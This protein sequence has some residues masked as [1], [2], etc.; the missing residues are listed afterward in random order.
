MANKPNEIRIAIP[1]DVQ[2][3]VYA[4]SMTITHT[5]EEFIMDF[6]LVTPPAGTVNARVI[7]SPGHVKRIISAL[8]ENVRRYEA[9]FGVIS[10]AAEPKGKGPIGFNA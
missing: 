2:A 4:N 7:T 1:P 6:A 10:E 9:Q 3:G 8:R 5:K